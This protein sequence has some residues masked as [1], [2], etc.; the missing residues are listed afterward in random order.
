MLPSGADCVK[1]APTVRL[2]LSSAF[3][4]LCWSPGFPGTPILNGQLARAE[5]RSSRRPN[6]STSQEIFRH[7]NQHRFCFRDDR[8]RRYRQASWSFHRVKRFTSRQAKSR[9][10]KYI[11]PVHTDSVHAWAAKGEAGW[12]RFDLIII[13][14]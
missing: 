1:S 13:H 11:D 9:C 3:R 2:R 4:R 14:V 8:N 5:A 10:K 12:V 6:T 7:E